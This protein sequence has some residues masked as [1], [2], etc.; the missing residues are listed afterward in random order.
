[1]EWIPLGDR[2]TI[3][4][5]R[6]RSTCDRAKVALVLTAHNV[7]PHDTQVDTREV[8]RRNLDLAH[9]VIAHTEHVAHDLRDVLA[10]RSQVAVVPHGPLF[11]DLEL[12]PRQQAEAELGLGVH[13]VILFAGIVRPYKGIDL[14]TEAWPVV[15]DAFP[16]AVLVI[17]GRA[18]GAEACE[19]LRKLEA[20]PGVRVADGYVPMKAVLN[21]HAVSDVVVFPYRSISQSGALMSAV[22]L[23]R[24]A[25]VTP[26]AG[27]IEQAA[28]LDSVVLADEVSG[29][30][31]ARATI[32]ALEDRVALLAKAAD[33][34]CRAMMS[35]T[36]WPAA[37]RETARQY[38]NAVAG[39]RGGGWNR[40]PGLVRE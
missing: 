2:Q 37:G 10:A 34:R 30:A 40:S 1:M 11:A 33:D 12:P 22:G 26:I 18:L 31:I 19:Q 24:P 14:L 4:M 23:G 17:A 32:A 13:P 21:Y 15:R 8:I 25:V 3:F 27:F 29:P 28:G 35:P 39:I 5:R 9:L 38:H 6:L 16:E 20:L 36:G 7:L